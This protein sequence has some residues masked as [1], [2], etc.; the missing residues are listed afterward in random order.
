MKEVKIGLIGAGEIAQ[1]FHLPIHYRLQ[2]VKLNAIYDK[3]YS[4]AQ[5]IAEKFEIP[6]VCKSI[7]EIVNYPEIDA[8]DIC[9]STDVHCEIALAA[10]EAGKHCFI[11]K[12]VARN[13]HEAKMIYEAQKKTDL[14]VMVG[15]NQRFRYD[16]MMLK[17]FVQMGEI[18]N[19]FYVQGS[20]LQQKRG[21]EW[22]QQLEKSGGGVLMDLG[23]SLI[24]SLLWICG[25]P[26]VYSVSATTFKHL[27]QNV[28]DVCISQIKFKNG[29]LA[30]LEM[31]W[32]LFSSKNT[33]SFNVYGNHG[34]AKINPLQLFKSGGDVFEP[35]TNT[36]TLS[37]IAIHKKSFE[38]EIKHFVNSILGLGNAIS[39]TEEAMK[40]MKIIEM[41]YRSAEE[42]TE[43]FVDE[44]N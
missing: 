28:E 10:I 15:T 35:I 36:D 24:D 12:P 18:G 32:S 13:Y 8:V 5:A 21:S 2:N 34:S 33:F 38:S 39:T 44:I 11:E 29:S 4:K 31:S 19:I 14:K 1:N 40:T 27:T 37:N 17:N 23:I 20:W 25:Y 22:K 43:I 9:A 41:M 6:Y 16:A 3:V 42:K 7:D 26:E 30:T